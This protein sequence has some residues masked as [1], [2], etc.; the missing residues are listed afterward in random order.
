MLNQ[1]TI[2]ATSK[3]K[4]INGMSLMILS[5]ILLTRTILRVN[6]LAVYFLPMMMIMIGIR[7]RIVRVLMF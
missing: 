7:G 5:L 2:L 3:L 6:V 4:I 1:A